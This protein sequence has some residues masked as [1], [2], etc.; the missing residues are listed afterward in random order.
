MEFLV[1][2][3]HFLL[4]HY[5]RDGVQDSDLSFGFQEDDLGDS[6]TDFQGLVGWGMENL[7]YGVRAF[8]YLDAGEYCGELKRDIDALGED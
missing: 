7:T 2:A 3:N 6:C 1:D 5:G 8:E 4:P